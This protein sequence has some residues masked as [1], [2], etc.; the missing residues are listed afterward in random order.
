MIT[1]LYIGAA[2]ALLLLFFFG[3]RAYMRFRGVRLVTCPETRKP[4]ALDLDAVRGVTSRAFGKQTLR[5]Q[6]CSR[7]PERRNCGRECLQQ[8]ETAPDDCL[9]R[10]I[11]A[12]WYRGKACVLC[13]TAFGE[14]DW[15]EHKPCFMSPQR[16][17]AEWGDI[18]PEKIPSVFDTSKPVCWKCHIAESF[19]R[20][21][22]DLVV[23]RN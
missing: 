14:I 1:G 22:P 6:N 19:R 7:W 2:T 17:T 11:V 5:L 13:G 18:P 4:A 3:V 9:V 15:L 12:N 8:V 21:F 16:M 10:N 20:R 23:D